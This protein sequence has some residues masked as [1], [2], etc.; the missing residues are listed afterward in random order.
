M[1]SWY[2]PAPERSLKAVIWPAVLAAGPIFVTVAALA[3]LYAQLP[4]PVIIDQHMWTLFLLA[5]GVA[6]ALGPVFSTLPLVAGAGL[7][8]AAA[9]RVPLLRAAICWAAAGAAGAT[10][11]LMQFPRLAQD[12]EI[13]VALVTTSIVCAL[14]A[15]RRS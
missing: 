3:N 1:P 8:R 7:M 12:A 2:D 5:F 11:L 6:A 15:H 13:A 10:A 9:S 4:Q 14:L